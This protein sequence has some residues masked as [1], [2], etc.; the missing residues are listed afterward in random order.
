MGYKARI[1]GNNHCNRLS[2]EDDVRN[3]LEVDLQVVA[4]G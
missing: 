1:K 3:D 2:E 4:V